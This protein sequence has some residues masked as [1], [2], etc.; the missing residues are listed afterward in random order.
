MTG[1]DILQSAQFVTIKGNRLVIIDAN[2]WEAFMEW[3]EEIEDLQIAKN[4][5]TGLKQIDGNRERAGLLKWQDVE[6]E[7][8]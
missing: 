4:F 3:L 1:I 6:Q 8:E 2:E 7:L 5:Y